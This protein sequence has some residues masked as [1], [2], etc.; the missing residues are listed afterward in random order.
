M[1]D[2]KTK[3]AALAVVFALFCASRAVA[4]TE[5]ELARL[6]QHL[7]LPDTATMT[8][9]SK[10][11]LHPRSP[12]NLYIATGANT[13]A[14]QNVVKWV[15]E[16]NDRKGDK[17]GTLRIVETLEESDVVLAQFDVGENARTGMAHGRHGFETVTVAPIFG[18]VVARE[19]GELVVVA[20]YTEE[21]P[22]TESEEAGRKLT[23]KLFELMKQRSR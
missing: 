19:K 20:R 12:L 15:T 18:Y 8:L 3:R 9:A 10:P 16:W 14:H 13:A 1:S 7:K 11:A 2:P 21:G 23:D 4:S 22:L 6:R 5:V 17:Y